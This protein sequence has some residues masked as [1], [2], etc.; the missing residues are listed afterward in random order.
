MLPAF[1][2][3]R[4]GCRLLQQWC[5][6]RG[7]LSHKFLPVNHDASALWSRNRR[8]R[9]EGLNKFPGQG[10]ATKIN[11]VPSVLLHQSVI[12]F[13]AGLFLSRPSLVSYGTTDHSF[14]KCVNAIADQ[15]NWIG[16][17]RFR[18]HIMISYSLSVSKSSSLRGVHCPHTC[19]SG[20]SILT[21]LGISGLVK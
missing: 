20:S 1:L 12:H 7:F 15:F 2:R 3:R 4:N 17:F 8:A 16:E 14:M 13:P 10:S 11:N 5:G 9:L 18:D 21:V 6:L 19:S